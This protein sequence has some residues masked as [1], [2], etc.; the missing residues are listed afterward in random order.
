MVDDTQA[1]IDAFVESMVTEARMESCLVEA[2]NGGL[3]SDWTNTFLSSVRTAVVTVGV[4]A[5]YANGLRWWQV[6]PSVTK[7]AE[8]WFKAKGRGR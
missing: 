3:D 7:A 5:L 2:C 1:R 4:E 6:R 8:E